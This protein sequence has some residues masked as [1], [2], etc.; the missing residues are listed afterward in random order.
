M[1]RFSVLLFL[2]KAHLQSLLKRLLLF[3]R[4]AITWLSMHSASDSP[5]IAKNVFTVLWL[6]GH[7]SLL[8]NQKKHQLIVIA[9][10]LESLG[11]K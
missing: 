4:D 9:D 2:V 11:L 1:F 6:L 5:S 10:N 3:L 7:Y 8:S